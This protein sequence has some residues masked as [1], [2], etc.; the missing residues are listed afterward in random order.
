MTEQAV[1][2][3]PGPA[4]MPRMTGL[5]YLRA[6]FAARDAVPMGATLGFDGGS[7]EEG[8][9][10]FTCSPGARHCN[11][12]GNVHGGLAATL[13]DSAMGCAVH[14]GLPAG[15]GYTTAELK[16]NYI[17]AMTP[18]TGPVHAVG[19]VV[20]LGRQLAVAEGRLTG[21]DGRLYATG[22]TTCLIFPLRAG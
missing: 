21:A 20:H 17:R 8:R 15:T 5:D 19:T 1:Q 16:I 10:E 11:P 12:M 4:E 2:G 7:F 3:I 18:D 14:T 13:L 9:A 6:V 22:S